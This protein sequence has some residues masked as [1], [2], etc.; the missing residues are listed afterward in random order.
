MN[1][2]MT[3]E[4]SGVSQRMIRH[5]GKIG[6]IPAPPRRD[7]GYRDY[8]EADVH[9][10]RFIANARDLGFSIEEIRGLL[11][12]WRDRHRASSEVRALASPAPKRWAARPMPYRPCGGPCWIS[13]NDA[14]V[15]A[16]PIVRSS[17]SCR[18]GNEELVVHRPSVA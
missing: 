6:L 13:P 3:A 10:L 11:G 8:S 12:L 9:T 16:V 5:Y 1:I 15:T 7:S 14:M 18:M 4:A 2:G 17:T